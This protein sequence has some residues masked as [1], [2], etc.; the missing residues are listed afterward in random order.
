[1][2]DARSPL[3]LPVDKLF[4]LLESTIYQNLIHCQ[5]S[6]YSD[7]LVFHGGLLYR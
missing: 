5:R 4:S 6:I 2:T 1:M 7:E 3:S